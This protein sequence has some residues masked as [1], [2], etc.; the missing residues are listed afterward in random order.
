MYARSRRCVNKFKVIGI[1]LNKEK[2]VGAEVD[3]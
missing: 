2:R 3:E 1:F